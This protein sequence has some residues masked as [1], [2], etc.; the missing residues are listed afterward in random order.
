MGKDWGSS[1]LN[2][3]HFIAKATIFYICFDSRSPEIK[4]FSMI[5][6][7]LKGTLTGKKCVR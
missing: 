3:V 7:N 4:N 2:I 6:S 5:W 1:I